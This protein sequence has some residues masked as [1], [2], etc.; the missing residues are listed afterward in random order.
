ATVLALEKKIFVIFIYN[1]FTIFVYF[2]ECKFF[3]FGFLLF[4]SLG[5]LLAPAYSHELSKNIASRST[6]NIFVF[7]SF[8][9]SLR[10]RRAI[11]SNILARKYSSLE[12]DD[13]VNFRTT[14][15]P[16]PVG[17]IRWLF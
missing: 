11:G 14:Q 9:F 4:L 1:F 10:S 12:N 2:P 8:F 6:K 15:C 16:Y 5:H 3:R 17:D 7:F 13:L